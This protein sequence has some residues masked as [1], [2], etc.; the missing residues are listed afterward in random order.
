MKTTLLAAILI[1][2]RLLVFSQPITVCP[3]TQKPLADRW[4]WAISEDKNKNVHENFW[5][6]YSFVK[7]M[8]I[9]SFTGSFYSDSKRNKPTLCELLGVKTCVRDEE[10]F[11]SAHKVSLTDG[12]TIIDTDSGEERIVP[13]EVGVLFEFTHGTGDENNVKKIVVSNFS[14][15]VDLNDEPVYWLGNAQAEES[16]QLLLSCFT[17]SAPTSVQQSIISAIGLHP[18]SKEVILT[19]SNI[20]RGDAVE[21]V[22]K[23]AAFWLGETNSGDALVVLYER[24]LNDPSRE[25]EESCVFGISQMKGGSASD[26][27]IALARHANDRETKKKAMFWL[28]QKASKKALTA[29]EKFANDND[30]TEIQKNAVFALTQFPDEQGLESLI[31]IAKTHPNPQ[32][33]KQAIFWLGE[34]GGERALNT[35]VEILKEN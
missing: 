11:G 28:G 26:S 27:L 16:I 14:L 34:N 22:R 29:L 12:S 10:S 20:L 25:V 4:R 7:M 33:R 32:V 8:Q 30:D 35:L 15:H 6:G 17:P 21:A 5:I 19:L 31:R 18:P 24:A 3:A 13:K 2:T 23:D 1:S 9:N